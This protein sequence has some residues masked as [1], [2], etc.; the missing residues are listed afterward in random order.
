MYFFLSKDK[1]GG[2]FDILFENKKMCFFFQYLL[3]KK[4]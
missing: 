4:Q 1:I 2:A 3:E